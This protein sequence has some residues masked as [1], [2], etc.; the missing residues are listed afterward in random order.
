[1]LIGCGKVGRTSTTKIQ[2]GIK[3]FCKACF[4]YRSDL[5][6]Q[7]LDLLGLCF[8][9][10]APSRVAQLPLQS[11]SDE[12]AMWQEIKPFWFKARES[13]FIC[14]W[15]KMSITV[16]N[17]FSGCRWPGRRDQSPSVV[18]LKKYTVLW[19]LAL[20]CCDIFPSSSQHGQDQC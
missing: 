4:L 16:D 17:C 2:W 11:Q 1:M 14:F 20:S 7:C 13:C 6:E 9:T 15:L 12:P 10:S 5:F 19:C 3:P 18:T 8:S